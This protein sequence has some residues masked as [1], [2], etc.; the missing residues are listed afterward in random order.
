MFSC[1]IS[2]RTIS[3]LYKLTAEINAVLLTT[4]NKFHLI[5]YKFKYHE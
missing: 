2:N 1:S 4:R 3:E 5:I